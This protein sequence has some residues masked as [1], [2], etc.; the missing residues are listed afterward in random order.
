MIFNGKVYGKHDDDFNRLLSI[1]QLYKI[2]LTQ[3]E[4]K[5]DMLKEYG[6][7]DDLLN[8]INKGAK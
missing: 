1:K 4:E 5:I 2:F 8:T 3:P 7:I 6:I